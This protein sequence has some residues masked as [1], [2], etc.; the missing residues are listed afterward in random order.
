MPSER[1]SG[2]REGRGAGAGQRRARGLLSSLGRALRGPAPG[3][4]GAEAGPRPPL[5]GR[6][7]TRLARRGGAI[8]LAQFRRVAAE[9]SAAGTLVT[10]ADREIERWIR[11]EMGGVAPEVAV[12]GEEFAAT[13]DAAKGW[14]LAVDPIDGTDAYVAGLP[15][16]CVSLGLLYRGAPVAGVVYLPAFDDLYLAYGGT[17]RWNGAEVPPGGVAPQHDGFVLAYSE[18]HRRPLL[19]LR[20]KVRALGSTAYHL[21]LVARGAA[22]AAIVGRVHVWDVAAG[23]ALL[24]A[25]GGELVYLRSGQP[26]DLAPL[27]DGGPTRDFMLAARAGATQRVLQRIGRR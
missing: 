8:G 1:G 3:A 21:S 24:D 23:K 2:A 9:R 19:R 11:T 4:P 16:W 18:F 25:V 27:L 6:T 7:L 15:T 5:D 26:V 10:E 14:A 22:E 20:G 12:I 17:L 13:G